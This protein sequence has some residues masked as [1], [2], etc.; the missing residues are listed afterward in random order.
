MLHSKYSEKLDVTNITGMANSEI[1]KLI[2]EYNMN[3]NMEE[4][5][6]ILQQIDSIAT[7]EFHWIFSWGAPY[8]YRCLNWDKFGIPENGVGY[9]GGWLQPISMWWIDPDKKEKL[10]DV[11]KN[12]G[13]IPVEKEVVD[14]WNNLEKSN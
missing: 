1:D 12:G 9:A 10:Q 7:R 13:I 6:Q 8:G 2:E 5:I 3:W 4:R 14:Y 11:I